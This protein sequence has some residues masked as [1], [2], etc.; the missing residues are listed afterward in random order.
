MPRRLEPDPFCEKVGRRIEDVRISKDLTLEAL[1]YRC[2]SGKGHLSSVERGL[3][4][5]TVVTL[6]RI[7][8]GLDER[9]FTMLLFPAENRFDRLVEMLRTMTPAERNEV[10]RY[11]KQILKRK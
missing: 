10:E 4:A 11:A 3:A 1:G 5:I 8:K 2:A 6:D 9:L 7:A